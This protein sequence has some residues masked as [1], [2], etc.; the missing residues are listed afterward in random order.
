[1]N[2]DF[3]QPPSLGLYRSV[4]SVFIL[5]GKSLG[6]WCRQNDVSLA[7][8]KDSLIGKNNGKK[9]VAVRNQ[10]IADVQTLAEGA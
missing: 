8:V 1:M 9:S 5:N 7:M 10:I 3:T 2:L 6:S 4:R